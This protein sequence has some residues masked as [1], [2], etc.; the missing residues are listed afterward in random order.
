MS[1]HTPKHGH[2]RGASAFLGEKEGGGVKELSAV[3]RMAFRRETRGKVVSPTLRGCTSISVFFWNIAP[4]MLSVALIHGE[5]REMLL[6]H[7]RGMPVASNYHLLEKAFHFGEHMESIRKGEHVHCRSHASW[8]KNIN[9][10]ILQ[11]TSDFMQVLHLH[12]N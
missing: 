11:V 9:I 5:G 10:S 8:N 7:L 1:I 3:A 4:L 6:D 2:I 12:R